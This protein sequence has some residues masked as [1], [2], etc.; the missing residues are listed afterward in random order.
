MKNKTTKKKERKIKTILKENKEKILIGLT[1]IAAIGI[2]AVIKAKN[3]KGYAGYSDEE[4]EEICR[5]GF[6]EENWNLLCTIDKIQ[7]HSNAYIGYDGENGKYCLKDFGKFGKDLKSS[8][9]ALKSDQEIE[10]AIVFY[11]EKDSE[12]EK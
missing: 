6:G 4:F 7:H 10:G 9:D 8:N 5:K 11:S 12:T 2:C 3:A 1:G